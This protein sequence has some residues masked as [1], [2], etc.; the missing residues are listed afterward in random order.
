M[1][2]QKTRFFSTTSIKLINKTVEL[3]YANA[4]CTLY[5]ITTSAPSAVRVSIKTAV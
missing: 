2:D 1:R 4:N 5:F 3:N